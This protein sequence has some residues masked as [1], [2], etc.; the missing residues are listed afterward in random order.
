VDTDKDPYNAKRGFFYTHVGWMLMQQDYGI[1][2]LVD[3]ADFTASKMIMFQHNYY[4]PIALLAGILLPCGIAGYGWG[5]AL[6]GLVY[7]GLLKMIIVHH[8]TFFINSLAHTSLF[9]AEQ[10]FSDNHTSHDS[11][12]CALLTLGEGYHNFHHE[13]A[14]DYRNGIKWWH[15]DPTKWA[16]RFF[17]IVGM[18]KN[19][20]RVPNKVIE[21]NVYKLCLKKHA[22]EM[23][24]IRSR[25]TSLE[26]ATVVQAT[27]T[28]AEFEK[29]VEKG[30]RLVVVGD[31]VLDLEKV[32]PT[33]PGYTHG[34]KNVVW[35]EAH[36]GGRPILDSFVG[37]D[38]TE[39]MTGGVYRHSEGAFNLLHHL[40]VAH[41][42]RDKS[43]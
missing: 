20:V 19:L 34:S 22:A 27:M 36:P 41:L 25:L 15:Y 8:T 30:A 9:G 39:A 29:R 4:L 6:G 31:H 23:E 3:V 32:V 2:G 17:E 1:L 5:D 7:A 38:A 18:A 40:R 33:G 35:Y 42:K 12:F 28:W 11:V 26:K 37:K 16:I 24:E 10:H 21:Q 13:F 43:E 14:Q